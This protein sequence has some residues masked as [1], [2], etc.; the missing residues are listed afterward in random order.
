[1]AHFQRW[2]A[3]APGKTRNPITGDERYT[4]LQ[5]VLLRTDQLID[6]SKARIAGHA[7]LLERMDGSSPGHR[8][9]SPLRGDAL[10][11]NFLVEV[12]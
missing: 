10:V 6:Q 5:E 12:A 4:H 9:G 2:Y 11:K 8:R 3:M 7:A 1:M